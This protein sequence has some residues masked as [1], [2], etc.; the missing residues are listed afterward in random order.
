MRAQ[1]PQH[2]HVA[3]VLREL[4]HAVFGNGRPGL[5][6]RVD[7]METKI[8][9]AVKLLWGLMLLAVPSFVSMVI[10]IAHFITKT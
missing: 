5:T 10:A 2:D 1:C 3:A 4:K 6:S 7:R 8:D 9:T